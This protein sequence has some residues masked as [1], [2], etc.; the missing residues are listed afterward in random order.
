MIS[1][2]FHVISLV[3]VLLALAVG[4]ALGGGPLSEVGRGSD[5]AS[6]AEKDRAQLTSDLKEAELV[7]GFQDRVTASLAGS[8]AGSALKGHAVSVVTMPGADKK[9]V[10]AL[11]DQVSKAGGEV[12]GTY[13]MSNKL[14]SVDGSSLVDSLGSQLVETTTNSGVDD[15]ATTYVRMGQLIRRAIA[16]TTDSGADLDKGSRNIISGLD[17]AKLFSTVS[18]GEKRSSLVLVVLGDAPTGDG[19]DKVVGGLVTGLVHGSDGVVIGGETE[20]AML[21]ALRANEDVAGAVSTVDSV[22]SR[23]GQ[24]A[25]VLALAAEAA[26]GPG[27][28][29]VHGKDGALPRG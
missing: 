11:T 16:S 15:G 19:A 5:E 28:F 4:V 24:L 9:Q 21:K 14:L 12:S 1:F 20:S 13:A 3:A 6:A 8:K 22:Q 17:A 18:G 10:D 2:R 29:G 27:S 25:A 7:A 26:G 23:S